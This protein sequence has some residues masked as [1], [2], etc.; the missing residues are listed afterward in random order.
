[1]NSMRFLFSFIVFSCLNTLV[2]QVDLSANTR[3]DLSLIE[4]DYKFNNGQSSAAIK[5]RFAVYS[6]NQVDYFGA[7]A[8]I[9]DD[10]NP[11]QL[12]TMG[13]IVGSKINSIVSLK[14]PVSQINNIEVLP[15][16][17]FLQLAGKIKPELDKAI[18]D[19]GADSV[20]LGINLPQGYTGKDVFIGITDWGFDYTSPMFY[21]TLLQETR[22][23]AAWD[24]FKT[25]GPHPIGFAYGT[26]YTTPT[27]L[28]AAGS[29]TANIYSFA[30]HGSHVA[31][32][33]GG[34][35]AGTI[36][37][38]VGF[39]S[40]LLFATFLV[41][42]SAVMDAWAWMYQKAQQSS[43][44]LVI[45]MSWGLYHFGTLDGNSL[46]SQ[47]ID[48]Y[49]AQGVL[50]ANSGGNN[51][52]VNFHIK[53]DFQ[54]DTI[55]SKI[56]FY[57]YTAN[58]NMW[59][60]SIHAWGEVGNSFSSGLIVYD[61]NG[62]L[63]ASTP[64]FTTDG[65][66]SYI[67]SFLVVGLD[68]IYFNVSADAAHPQ[69]GRPQMRIRVKS[70]SATNKVLLKSTAQDGIVH[71][72]NVTELSNDVGNWGMPFATF[73]TGSIAG[74]KLYGISEP[75]CTNS[76]L[77]VAAYTP[78]FYNSSGTALGGII[79]PFSSVGPRYDEVLKPEIAAPGVNI[80]SSIS[81]FTDNSFTQVSS[82]SFNNRTYPFARF[83]GTSMASPMVAGVIALV[84]EANP[85]LSS[86][87]VKDIIIQSAREDTQTGVIPVNGSSQWGWGKINAYLAVKL[88]LNTIGF[89]EVEQETLWTVYPNPVMQQLHFT[90][91]DEL[92]STIQIISTLGT[93]I[94]KKVNTASIDVSDLKAGSYWVRVELN[95]RI[96]Q[97]QF[98]KL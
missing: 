51:G 54:N 57:S 27:T 60:Q 3:A 44:R 41:D 78:R 86:A 31:G 59:G 12:T 85:Y 71:Y 75:S 96:Q 25:S 10:Y 32:I 88:A 37:R 92:P 90:V 33:A 42:E 84:L 61:Q 64:L 46:L 19:I 7:L 65:L 58:P 82:I 95:G 70:L 76:L 48:N 97:Q 52:D 69:N 36:H 40:K 68:T 39:E 62:I 79:A 17:S 94:A 1:M 66:S 49:S 73:G 28:L 91:V 21:D 74:D 9:S 24:Q 87:Q 81:S 6:F 23:H 47:A 20:H 45:N 2:A 18:K 56:N 14:I 93:V 67:D 80:V 77:S 55:K 29:D 5:N 53:K 16:L 63:A 26:E 50:F 15:G 22:I 72:W 98:I 43:K 13:I 8:K 38:G 4:K 30:T 89:E 83:S 34:S 35:G 11:S